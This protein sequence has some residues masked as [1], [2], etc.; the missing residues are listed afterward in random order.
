MLACVAAFARGVLYVIA[1]PLIVACMWFY[2]AASMFRFDGTDNYEWA[3][4]M[5]VVLGGTFS[6]PVIFLVA[7]DTLKASSRRWLV[8]IACALFVWGCVTGSLICL[9]EHQH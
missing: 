8:T 9:H 5:D 4:K 3:L 2:C 6:I 7:P 1:P